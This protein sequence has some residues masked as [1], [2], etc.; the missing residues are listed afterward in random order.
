MLSAKG[1]SD[2]YR[3]LYTVYMYH[4]DDS[5]CLMTPPCICLCDF[6]GEKNKYSVLLH[7]FNEFSLLINT[8]AQIK[9][10]YTVKHSEG[11][12]LES[13]HLSPVIATR[14]KENINI[15]I[16]LTNIVPASR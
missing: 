15:V 11:C 2:I 9:D 1:H 3:R 14:A 13:I 12:Y 6:L 10:K 7:Q 16:I 5:W 8:S 4:T